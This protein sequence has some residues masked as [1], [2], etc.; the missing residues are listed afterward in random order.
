MFLAEN[1]YD[2]NGCLVDFETSP[3]VFL[4]EGMH[5]IEVNVLAKPDTEDWHSK[6]YEGIGASEAAAAI[7]ESPWTTALE[8][9]SLK[10]HEI[11]PQSTNDAM[12]MGLDIEGVIQKQF[13]RRYKP[14]ECLSPIGLVRHRDHPWMLAS[15]DGVARWGNRLEVCEWKWMRARSAE[16]LGE[17]GTDEIPGT[18][19]WQVQQQMACLDGN[20]KGYDR[21]IDTANVAVI[22]DGDLRRY[23]VKRNE[24]LIAGLIEAEGDLWRRIQKNDPPPVDWHHPTTPDLIRKLHTGTDGEVITLSDESKEAWL[25]AEKLAKEIKEREERREVC[26]AKAIHELAEHFGG[27]L[28]DGRLIRRLWMEETP[29]SYVRKGYWD[30]RAVK[31]KTARSRK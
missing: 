17:E 26:K 1:Q 12:Q 5:M 21:P 15:P 30:V 22:V 16:Q 10:R 24:D 8:L 11:P 20:I 31:E 25:E 23:T 18:W 7:G 3:A 6:R 19:I 9:F 13:V 28:G 2:L 14:D 29:V 27:L 4:S